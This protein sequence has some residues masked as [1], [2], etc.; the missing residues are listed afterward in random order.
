MEIR[1]ALPQDI[2]SV[3]RLHQRYHIDSISETLK[4]DG[5]VTT[6]FTP[7]QLQDLVLKEKGITIAVENGEV[8]A[9]AMA[10][11]WQFWSAWPFFTH[12]IGELPKNRF[13]GVA[14]DEFNSYQYGPVC[15]DA[16]KRGT[17]LF[18]Q[19]FFASLHSMAGRYPTMVTFIN[20]V[21]KRSFA[22]HTGKVPL[23]VVGTF[24]FNGNDY[25][26]LACSTSEG[27]A[28]QP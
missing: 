5:F 17:G 7:Q 3:M 25:Y 26:M 2:D 18:Q 23:D 20:K 19:V 27:M 9:Y 21:N 12:M 13:K 22:A 14:L 8:F 6:N 15:V 28:N 4:P 16:S 1:Q 11:S 24:Q 10:A